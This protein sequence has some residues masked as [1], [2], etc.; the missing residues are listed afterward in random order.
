[1]T[2]A[3]GEEMAIEKQTVGLNVLS[4]T[5]EVTTITNEYVENELEA[6]GQLFG[7][8][9]DEPFATTNHPMAFWTT[10]GWKSLNL[11]AASEENPDVEYGILQIG[12]TVFRISQTD[13]LLYK[14]V[15]IWQLTGLSV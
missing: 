4:N 14:P 8:N 15:T 12:D 5:G 1:M 11:K 9:D 10:E 13:L 7:I 6:G 2:L 3:S